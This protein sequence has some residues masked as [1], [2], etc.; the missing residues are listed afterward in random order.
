MYAEGLNFEVVGAIDRRVESL[1]FYF[2]QAQCDRINAARQK[3]NEICKAAS[4][5]CLVEV[6]PI[7]P[8]TDMTD[9]Y[10]LSEP[11]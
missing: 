10:F 3:A 7:R 5:F 6:E 8:H 11:T 1:E 9:G 2:D 4:S